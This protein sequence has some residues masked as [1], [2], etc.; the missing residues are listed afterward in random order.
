MNRRRSKSSSVASVGGAADEDLLHHRL[1]RLDAFAKRGIVDRHVAPA[2]HV[3]ALGRD[4]LLDDFAH[5]LAR[6]GLARHEE[7]ADRVMA[8]RRQV[9]AELGA[10]GGEERVRDLGQHAA[11]V[12]E[13]RIRAHRAA[14][15]EVDQNLQALFEDVVRLAVLHVGHEADAAGI[16]LLGGIVERLGRRRQRVPTGSGLR[17]SRRAARRTSLEF[18]RSSFRSPGGR[19]PGATVIAKFS[20]VS[21]T[22]AAANAQ[23]EGVTRRIFFDPSLSFDPTT[24]EPVLLPA[25]K[26]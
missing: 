8:W 16:V 12:A 2:E 10:F 18:W 21:G 13:R 23:P 24:L 7:L 19:A 11:A 26:P 25:P 6:R 9:E 3:Q 15:V 22:K 17:R 1:D 4:D 14:M 5:L 20:G